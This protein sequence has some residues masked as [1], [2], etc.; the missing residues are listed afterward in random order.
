MNKN[1]ILVVVLIIVLVA[2]SIGILFFRTQE[3][4]TTTPTP[5]QSALETPTATPEISEEEKINQNINATE[6]ANISNE[7]QD[8]DT[9]I[10]KLQ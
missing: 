3:I 10:K 8:I 9:N 2:I 4:I 6:Q 7:F 5:D 1:I